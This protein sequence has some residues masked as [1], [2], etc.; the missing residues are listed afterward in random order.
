MDACIYIIHINYNLCKCYIYLFNFYFQD[1]NV[2]REP[3]TIQPF[4]SI[5]AHSV[6]TELLRG[7]LEPTSSP[8][9]SHLPHQ[10]RSVPPRL[11]RTPSISS[12]SS[13][14]SAQSRQ[15][16]KSYLCVNF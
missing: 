3:H 14:D 13:L 15:S 12:Q 11:Q 6:N 10:N 4:S 16:V 9:H 1:C 8:M 5:P 7:S 2:L